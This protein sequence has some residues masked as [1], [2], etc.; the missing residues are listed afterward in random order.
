MTS[1]LNG[2]G[3]CVIAAAMLL[4]AAPTETRQ[5]QPAPQRAQGT[6]TDGVTAVLVDIVV[7]DRKGQPVRDLTQSDF[8]ILED[9]ASQSIG[10]FTRVFEGQPSTAASS[11]PPS[12]GASPAP[13]PPGGTL[14]NPG[15]GVTALVFDRLRPEARRLAAQAARNY[16]GSTEESADFV[17]IFGIDLSLTPYVPFTR[18]GVALRTALDAMVNNPSAGLPTAEQRRA[19][20]EATQLAT[21]S[22]AAA[23][24][25]TSGAAGPGASAAIGTSP[26]QAQLTAM[27]ADILRG[28]DAIDKDQQGYG[29]TNALFAIVRTLGRIPGRKSLVLF[30]EGI[31]IPDAVQHFYLGVIDAANRANVSIYTMDAVG[32]RAE[33][34]QAKVRDAVN[35]MGQ[36]GINSGYA[37]DG[38]GGSFTR[39][40]ESN[41]E[42]L[43]SDPALTLGE[44]AN[45]TGGLFFNNTNNLAPAFQ[46]IEGD[47]RN[48]YLI[49]YTPTNTTFDGKFRA[50]EVRVKRPNVTVAAR[51]GY[52]A[53]RDPGGT[54]VNSWEAPALAALE[55]KPVGND[56]PVRA[57]ALLFPERGRP[58]LV[59]VVVELRTAPLS[60]HP[61]TDNKS[62]TSDFTVLVR[63]I[64]D[65]NA[66]ARKISQHYEIR[67][68]ID[69]IARATQ[70]DVI[71]YRESEL[72]PGV[73]TL[74]TVVYDAPSGKSSV[75]FSTLEMPK[76]EDNVLRMSS[77][78]L[79]KRSEK[80]PEKDRPVGNPL[81]VNDLLIHPNLGDPVSKSAKE[82]GFYFSIYPVSGQPAPESTIELTLN[83]QL[84]A[85]VPMPVGPADAAGRVQQV[86]RLP[87]DQL[88]PGTY[89]LR[90]VVKQ[91][92]SVVA[93]STMLR[94][95]P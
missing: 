3:L 17:A 46:R 54:P 9:G 84:L 61:A 21:A 87:L 7:R 89:E 22:A 4:Q 70:G 42:S 64:D 86:G 10:S 81:L 85:R 45:G 36:I 30:S 14:I 75:R 12:S 77:L 93:R 74:E 95:E 47:L 73:Y 53:V 55:R 66:V 60:F 82:I 15:P 65:K 71:F 94:I 28:F 83:G 91:G 76:H 39:N 33:S 51:R 59:P 13:P 24:A 63:F 31:A 32:L 29:T 25:A 34:D 88:A 18:N 38:V 5:Q 11:A 48:Y 6:L 40:L 20:A 92:A 67:G 19:I 69:Q 2:S 44:L 8:E 37:G 58:G 56:F 26:A 90:A 57:G 43:R 41:A 79:V 16:L 80:A 23:N 78:V 52:F 49:G 62:Y 1:R 68:P 27:Q 50:I 35:Q 72:P